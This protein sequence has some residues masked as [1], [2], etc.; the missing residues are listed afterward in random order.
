[1]IPFDELIAALDRYKRRK[2]LEAAAGTAAPAT[3]PAAPKPSSGK[4]KATISADDYAEEL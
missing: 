1:M 4:G 2:E 3:P